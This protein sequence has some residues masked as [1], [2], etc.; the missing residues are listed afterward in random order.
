MHICFFVLLFIRV[1]Y[2]SAFSFNIFSSYH[3]SLIFLDIFISFCVPLFLALFPFYV[4]SS[5]SAR[6]I[7]KHLSNIYIFH[8]EEEL[9][10]LQFTYFP[11][12]LFKISFFSFVLVSQF[13]FFYIRHI[14]DFS[15][16]FAFTI[17]PLFPR[18]LPALKTKYSLFFFVFI[19]RLLSPHLNPFHFFSYS[20]KRIKIR[21]KYMRKKSHTQQIS[22]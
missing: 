15:F 2:F 21:T 12:F 5:S 13:V 6:S 10:F 22:L 18:K 7:L 19:I 20:Y 9:V 11:S 8:V 17:F 3:N 16:S 1:H 14:S 4:A